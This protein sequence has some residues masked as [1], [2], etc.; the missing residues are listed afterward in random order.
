MDKRRLS[1]SFIR[2]CISSMLTLYK[3]HCS[4]FTILLSKTAIKYYLKLFTTLPQQIINIPIGVFSKTTS[5]VAK[6]LDDSSCELP[7][8]KKKKIVDINYWD[9]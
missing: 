1:A 8:K 3:E 6:E 2:S 9:Y 7:N 4:H 5:P